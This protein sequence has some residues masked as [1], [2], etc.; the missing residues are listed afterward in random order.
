[1]TEIE[2]KQENVVTNYFNVFNKNN[3]TGN[4]IKEQTLCCIWTRKK[5]IVN[6]DIFFKITKI[7]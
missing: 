1:M 5:D 6:N 3:R 4:Y 7:A 2:H